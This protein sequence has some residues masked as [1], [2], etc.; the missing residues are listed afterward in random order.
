LL[1]SRSI[2]LIRAHHLALKVFVFN[3]STQRGNS[4]ANPSIMRLWRTKISLNL[5]MMARRQFIEFSCQTLEDMLIYVY[6]IYLRPSPS[7]RLPT[8][9]EPRPSAPELLSHPPAQTIVIQFA[10]AIFEYALSVVTHVLL[11]P[12]L[13]SC[14][15][16]WPFFP[17]RSTG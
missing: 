10:Y 5:H 15:S 6:P 14:R 12:R 4:A 9:G 8:R 16:I 1:N 17:A 3:G 13:R 2:S 7:K 11:D